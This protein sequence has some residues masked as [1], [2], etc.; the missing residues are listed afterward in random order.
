M[1]IDGELKNGSEALE[2]LNKKKK[3]KT[4]VKPTLQDVLKS[5]QVSLFVPFVSTCYLTILDLPYVF[6]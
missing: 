6:T 4:N 1:F 2:N 5:M 3:P